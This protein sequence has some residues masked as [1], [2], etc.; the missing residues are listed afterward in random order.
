MLPLLRTH[1]SIHPLSI[2]DFIGQTSLFS[3]KEIDV[4]DPSAQ[5]YSDATY[6]VTF[7]RFKRIFT[8]DL[9]TT[10]YNFLDIGFNFS[11]V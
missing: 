3:S 2:Q 9:G 10:P 5:N 7:E 11:N 6:T 8:N 1:A 4:L